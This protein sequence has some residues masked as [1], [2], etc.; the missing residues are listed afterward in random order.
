M[1]SNNLSTTQLIIFIFTA[2]F[3]YVLSG[4]PVVKNAQSQTT[5]V[6][7]TLTSPVTSV[8]SRLDGAVRFI[9]DLQQIHDQNRE[10]QAQVAQLNEQLTD[11]RT[12]QSKNDWLT[13]QLNLKEAKFKEGQ[14]V[15]VIRYE[16]VPSPGYVYV[17]V[18]SESSIKEG[19]WATTYDYIVGQVSSV[20]GSYAKVK[21]LSA[22]E[23]SIPIKVGA[24]S[25]LG[26][27]KGNLGIDFEVVGVPANAGIK[28]G[29]EVKL[30]DTQIANLE[31]YTFGKVK[32]ITGGDA[33]STRE[34]QIQLP[35][36]LLSL[37]YLVL[38]PNHV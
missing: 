15:P 38:M 14:L 13:S 21:L 32:E 8:T 35:V 28:V 24:N 12:I 17:Y 5:G 18:G 16:Y 33:E 3:L 29:D 1:K 22:P 20:S 31:Q 23:S 19:Y 2:A 30:A 27:L 25:T 34:L 37:T 9:T 26:V 36:D 4:L 10:L 6:L 11:L 7:T